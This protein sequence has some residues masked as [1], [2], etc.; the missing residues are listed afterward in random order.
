M[1][2]GSR[3]ISGRMPGETRAALSAG[4]LSRYSRLFQKK[5]RPGGPLEE[6][7][8]RPPLMKKVDGQLYR[9][10]S[11]TISPVSTTMFS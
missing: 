11:L 7:M 6:Q 10:I 8:K 1:G 3:Q 2:D 9:S 4:R 5:E